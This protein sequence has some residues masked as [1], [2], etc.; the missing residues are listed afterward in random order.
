M[1]RLAIAIT[2]FSLTACVKTGTLRDPLELAVEG[3]LWGGTAIYSPSGTVPYGIAVARE[4]SGAL[5]IETPAEIENEK[6]PPG[7]YQRFVVTGTKGKRV[8]RYRTAAGAGS[9]RDGVLHEKRVEKG[10]ARGTLAFASSDGTMEVALVPL[11]G[12]QMSFRVLLHGSVHL[13]VVLT[14]LARE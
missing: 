1:R 10:A 5:V 3:K 14:R 13:D 2:T 7:A 6:L 9:F 4:G 8:M 12:G 11:E